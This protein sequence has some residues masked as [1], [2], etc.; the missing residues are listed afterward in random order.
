MISA[1][2][3][4]G[5]FLSRLE[6][7]KL[8]R[9]FVLQEINL[10]N[11]PLHYRLVESS[12]EPAWFIEL[13]TP[14]QMHGP[15]ISLELIGIPK[16]LAAQRCAARRSYIC[17]G[18]DCQP[19]MQACRLYELVRSTPAKG[20]SSCSHATYSHSNRGRSVHTNIVGR[21]IPI[22]T[23]QP[24]LD[25]L[26][27]VKHSAASTRQVAPPGRRRTTV[28]ALAMARAIRTQA[29]RLSDCYQ[30]GFVAQR[31]GQ[32]TDMPGPG[33]ISAANHPKIEVPSP[34]CHHQTG[35]CKP[36]RAP[37]PRQAKSHRP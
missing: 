29:L 8:D 4:F 26:G 10:R 9:S 20:A 23:M 13:Y 30:I 33:P 27:C 32:A 1:P 37:V 24:L 19:R 3:F 28:Q 5:P 18:S 16:L 6:Q 34:S 14:A 11:D 22:P 25:A 2:V 31:R 36:D 35:A 7:R 12:S 21:R 15:P 17:S